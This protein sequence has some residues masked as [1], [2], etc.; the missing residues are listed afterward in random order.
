M[1]F[2]AEYSSTKETPKKVT[3]RHSVDG[4]EQPPI[5]Y[6]NTPGLKDTSTHTENPGP[7]AGGSVATTAA[8]LTIVTAATADPPPTSEEEAPNIDPSSRNPA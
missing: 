8:G 5:I 1:W 6:D 7:T 4:V 2:D 3:V